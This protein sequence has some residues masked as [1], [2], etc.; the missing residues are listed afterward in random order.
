MPGAT[1]VF[2]IPYPCSGENIDCDIFADWAQA[3]QDAV[4]TTRAVETRALNRPSARASSNVS[5]GIAAPGV[6]TNLV[7]QVENYDNNNIV[8][9]AV[10]NSAFTI[11]TRGWY[12][13]SSWAEH[14]SGVGITSVALALTHNGTVIYRRKMSSPVSNAN[15]DPG[16]QVIGLFNCAPAD[17]IRAQVLTTGAGALIT[18]TTTFGYLVSQA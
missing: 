17:V 9:L 5:Q 10:D 8:N 2:G 4:D 11:Q 12:L 3:I 15:L 1:P 13:F 14:L 7:Y 16:L 18:R 6:S